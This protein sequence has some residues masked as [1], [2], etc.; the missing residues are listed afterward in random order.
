MRRVAAAY[1][2]LGGGAGGS[3]EDPDPLAALSDEFEGDEL[4]EAWTEYAGG[5]AYDVSTVADGAYTFASTDGGPSI[6]GALWFGGFQGLLTY[7]EIEGDF[8]CTARVHVTNA[9]QD[10]RPSVA[11]FR[12]AGIAA[13]D[14]DRDTVLNYVDVSIGSSDEATHTAE[15]KTTVDGT[16][17][18][19]TTFDVIEWDEGSGELVAW[20]RLT[21]VGSTFTLDVS[22]DGDAWT[23]LQEVE[24]E[25]LPA[26][27]QVG[28]I[29][30][31]N[32]NVADVVGAFEFVRFATP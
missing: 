8:V 19:G 7:K 22:A 2:T 1:V 11:G 28:P 25:D 5:G 4:D 20:L 23:E 26:T 30:Y 9:A 3:E 27:L 18:S 21:R 6:P 32:Q 31:S 15:W 17:G 24:R 16:M 12:Q 14:P 13:H 10:D 29:V